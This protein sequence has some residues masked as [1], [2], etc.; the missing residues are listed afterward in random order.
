MEVSGSVLRPKWLQFPDSFRRSFAMFKFALAAVTGVAIAANVYLGGWAPQHSHHGELGVA[1]DCCEAKD[2]AGTVVAIPANLIDVKNTKCV[3]MPHD[4]V[5]KLWV[6][7]EGKA[8]H[9]CC[10]GCIEDF[11][12]EPQKYVKAL[13]AKPMDFG[14]GA[15]AGGHSGH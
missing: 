9:I 8:Y 1:E 3:V 15:P 12:K 13:E 6:Q 2:E 5:G 4:P 7:Y 10:P 11:N 14:I